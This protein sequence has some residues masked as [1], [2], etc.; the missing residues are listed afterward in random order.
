[1][2]HDCNSQGI[3]LTIRHFGEKL[4]GSKKLSSHPSP[5]RKEDVT[6]KLSRDCTFPLS[7]SHMFQMR[8]TLSCLFSFFID[9]SCSLTGISITVS[10]SGTN[11]LLVDCMSSASDEPVKT[12]TKNIYQLNERYLEQGSR[13][14]KSPG[15]QK[16][17]KAKEK[18]EN[19][20]SSRGNTKSFLK[21]S[22][23][24]G[25]F[26]FCLP[27]GLGKSFLVGKGN[28]VSKDI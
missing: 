2:F 19:S 11:M 7:F 28:V 12:K 25:K 3:S 15:K 24:S 4:R 10:C 13:S 14:G 26:R 1:M 21:V 5:F 8:V 16:F 18:S 17:F 9:S 22:E 27:L 23:K 20:V 6:L